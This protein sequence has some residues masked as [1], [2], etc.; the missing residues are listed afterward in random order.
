ML[1]FGLLILLANI[2]LKLLV[3]VGLWNMAMEFKNKNINASEYIEEQIEGGSPEILR[4]Q[5]N[6]NDNK[7]I[8]PNAEDDKDFDIRQSNQDQDEE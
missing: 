5:N 4:G 8:F 7:R 2:F 6:N 1:K 3:G